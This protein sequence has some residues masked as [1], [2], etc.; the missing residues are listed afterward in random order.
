MLFFT[1]YRDYTP[2]PDEF[3]SGNSNSPDLKTSESEY[4]ESLETRIEELQA[5]KKEGTDKVLELESQIRLLI[6]VSSQYFDFFIFCS[7]IFLIVLISSAYFCTIVYIFVTFMFHV[8]CN[9]F[10]F[11]LNDN[12]NSIFSLVTEIN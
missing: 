8:I 1:Y 3:D 11:S 2:S 12:Y 6:Q 7:I 9:G 4:V 5:A 10:E